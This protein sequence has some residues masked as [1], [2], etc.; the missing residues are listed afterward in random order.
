[1]KDLIKSYINTISTEKIEE[2]S[3]KN[4]VY[5]DNNELNTVEYVLKNELDE[6][7]SNTDSILNKYKNSFKVDNFIKIEK[8]LLEYKKRYKNY[9]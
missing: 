9:L 1:M 2:F 5:L 3:K 4:G 7:L 8:L 6:L